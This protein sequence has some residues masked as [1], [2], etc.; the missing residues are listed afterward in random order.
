MKDQD[1]TKQVLIAEVTELQKRIAESE[2]LRT[3]IE[4]QEDERRE[5][6]ARS[7]AMLEGLDGFICVCSPDYQLEFVNERLIQRIG[8]NPM[9]EKCY[10]ALHGLEQVCPWCVNE[11]VQRGETVQWETQSPKDNRWYCVVN[12][13]V[14]HRDGSISNLAVIQDITERKTVEL[15]LQES[16][17]R[18]RS[19][20]DQAAD[21]VFVH[22][23]DGRILDVNQQGCAALG[24]TRDELLSMSVTDIDP[25]A[26]PRGDSDKFWPNLPATFE[27]KHKRK[28]GTTFPVEI[29]LGAIEYGTS[30]VVL[31]MARDVSDRKKAQE[32]LRESEKRY[33]ELVENSNDLVYQI[34]TNGFFTFV[35]GPACRISG[36][37]EEE[38]VGLHFTDL[39]PPGYREET[40]KFYG[41]QLVNKI[42][43]TYYEFPF[44]TKNGE[45]KW[46][47]Q[48]VLSIMRED[49]IVGFQAITR[50]VTQRKQL[51]LALQDSEERYRILADNALAGVYLH[52]DTFFVY[53]N[54]RLE[55]ILGYTADELTK[56]RFWEIFHPDVREK[57]KTRGLA[58]YRGEPAP[59]HYVS[60]ILTKDG[61]TRWVEVSAV[62]TDYRG[63][64]ATTGAL[65]DITER[66]ETQDAL[67]KSEEFSRRLVE[68][69]PFG[70][71][72]VRADGTIE[73]VNPAAKRIGGIPEDQES[74]ALGKNILELIGFPDRAKAQNAF[75]KLLEGGS[76][77]DLEVPYTSS[78][79]R[80]TVLLVAAT[81]RLRVDG[82][83]EGAILMLTDISERKR[84]EEIQR[85]TAR[86]R[87]VSDL[88]GGVAHNFN[89]LLHVVIGHAELALM[90]LEAGEYAIVRHGLEKILKSSQLGAEVV[91]RLQSFSRQQESGQASE[92][93]LFDLSDVAG[94][95]AEVSQS[96]LPDADKEGRRVSLYT[97]LKEGC[98]INA[99]KDGIFSVIANLVRNAVEALPMG[100]DIDVT[101]AIEGDSVVLQ[102]KDTGIGISPENLGR[103]FNP[104][105]TTKAEAGAGLSLAS[106]LKI[107]E[108]CGGQI[109]V[110]SA[111]GQGTVFTVLFPLAEKLPEPAKALPER[112]TE[113]RLTILVIDDMEAITDLMK[114]SL[115]TYGHAV[116]TALSGEEGIEI[117]KENLADVVIC[118]LGMPGMNG[119]EVGQKVSAIC[120]ER[121]VPKTPF[122]L[123]TAWAGQETETQKIAR[124]CVD[125]VIGKPVRIET[126]YEVVRQVVEK[127]L[128]KE[129]RG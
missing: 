70:I 93:R 38:L 103:L 77:S 60:R 127:S 75:R 32:A 40:A 26:A 113:Q 122:I 13:P 116:L 88:A 101:S 27:A 36:Y 69:A 25:D 80:D 53:A 37:S 126:V 58:R 105:F 118:D 68:H 8:R 84:A 76:F 34:D 7:K 1:K 47:G 48:N 90:D 79:G 125:A 41:R 22:D 35:N 91:R 49:E 85:Q 42:P 119:W 71:V 121:R 111:E 128:P 81:P 82:A 95:A 89:N 94:Q 46:V 129:C 3:A 14:H 117:F 29:R 19:L 28:D 110:D 15:A 9:G 123:L 72:Y 45:V 87:A 52:Q 56:M 115:T 43:G 30:K 124:S 78:V 100:G 23:F 57:V 64:V 4:K 18:F 66:R 86:Y 50:D 102:V 74:P 99:H 108:D 54:R 21:A 39:I 83:V 10:K 24:Y 112:D 120:Q 104:F 97:R 109:L 61:E 114:K 96:W 62:A 59:S 92:T 73:Y 106:S 63:K 65:V 17:E 55:E 20:I 107:V 31:A 98:F 16:E 5:S 2:T 12:S 6:E 44:N 33:R 51:E 67:R 11:A